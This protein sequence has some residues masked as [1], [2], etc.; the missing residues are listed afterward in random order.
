MSVAEK[1]SK[2]G[3]RKL[4]AMDGGGIRGMLSIEVLAKIEQIVR[5]ASGDPKR[6]LADYF[7]LHSGEPG[8]FASARYS[9]RTVE[10]VG[11]YSQRRR[12]NVRNGGGCETA[13]LKC[14]ATTCPRQRQGFRS[15]H[16]AGAAGSG[17]ADIL[18]RDH[19][20]RSVESSASTAVRA[21]LDLRRV[22]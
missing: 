21:E 8:A 9:D 10:E 3:P 18:R 20:S 2:G 17:R 12:G 16:N 7:R 14:P 1:L 5:Q 6:T 11:R 22:H 15:G 4:L 13:R 19:D